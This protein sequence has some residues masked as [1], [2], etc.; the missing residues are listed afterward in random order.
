MNGFLTSTFLVLKN[1]A[2]LGLKP[3][4]LHIIVSDL[5]ETPTA[6]MLTYRPVTFMGP[7]ISIV[8]I[9]LQNNRPACN[10]SPSHDKKDFM[11]TYSTDRAL[12]YNYKVLY[13]PTFA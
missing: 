13:P 5:S 11:Q 9:L 12:I 2:I 7:A 4:L 8:C 3:F 10:T 6:M 1:I